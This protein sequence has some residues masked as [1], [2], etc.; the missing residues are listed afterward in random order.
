M[1]L[2]SSDTSNSRESKLKINKLIIKPMAT[3][4]YLSKVILALT[5][6]CLA[7]SCTNQAQQQSE[8]EYIEDTTAIVEEV[9]SEEEQEQAIIDGMTKWFYSKTEDDL[10]HDIT[11]ITATI[12]STN[13]CRY[14]SYGHTARMVMTLTYSTMYLSTPSTAVLLSFDD[15]KTDMCRYA[16]DFSSGFRVVFDNGNVDDRWTLIDNTPK[17]NV[18]F[19]YMPSKVKPF[20]AMLRSSKTCRIQVNLENVGMTTFDFNI[21]GLKWDFDKDNS[22]TVAPAE[23][24]GVEESAPAE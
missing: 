21:E 12:L 23:D 11:S 4:Q 6:P 18:I 2:E 17:R 8:Q 24:A 20:L 1:I 22:G 13:E 15:G 3:Y 5:L 14:D 19:M 9:T 10:T 16:E 7:L